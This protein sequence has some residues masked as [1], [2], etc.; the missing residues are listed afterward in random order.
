LWRAGAAHFSR[1]QWRYQLGLSIVHYMAE[2]WSRKTL[3]VIAL[4]LYIIGGAG[5][6]YLLISKVV[7][8]AALLIRNRRW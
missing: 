2:A 6:A 1:D 4:A 8:V 7:G 5:A 3:R